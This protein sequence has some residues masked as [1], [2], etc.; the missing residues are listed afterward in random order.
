MV[1]AAPRPIML[2]KYAAP[3]RNIMVMPSQKALKLPAVSPDRMLSDAPPSRDDVTISA[4]CALS[5]DVK[6]LMSS[7][8]MAPANVLQVRMADSFHHCDSS[9]ESIGM[10]A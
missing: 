2:T 10:S 9:P 5:V 6:T 3:M 8:M 4:T 7:G 1:I